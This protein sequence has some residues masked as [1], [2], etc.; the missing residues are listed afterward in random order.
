MSDPLGNGPRR[1]RVPP[2]RSRNRQPRAPGGP[3]RAQR[4]G[5]VAARG[6]SVT[7]G[8]QLTRVLV[9]VLSLAVLSRLLGPA[10]YGLVALALAVVAVGEVFREFGLSAAAVQ[11]KSLNPRQRDGLFWVNAYLGAT[12]TLTVA[13]G[14][15]V[16]ALA[17]SEPRLTPIARVL[18]LTFLLNG[19]AAQFRAGLQRQLRFS[20]LASV[21][22]V[23]QLLAALIGVVL[24]LRGAGYW[25]LVAQQVSQAAAALL[26]VVVLGGWLPRRPSRGE[27]LRPFLRYGWNYLG[28]QLI[29]YLGKNADSLVIGAHFGPV[30]LG[31]YN[32]AYQVLMGPLGQLRAPT[33]TVALPILSR[34][35]DDQRRYGEYV[36][37]GQVALGYTFLPAIAIAAGA[38]DPLV[39]VVLGDRWLPVVPIFAALACAAIFDTLPYVGYWVYLS[40]GL[41]PHLLRYTAAATA[42]RIACIAIGSTWGPVGV[43][44]GIAAAAGASWPLSL[45]RLSRLTPLPLAALVRGGLRILA[46]VGAAG[47]VSYGVSQ[48]L[49][50]WHPLPRL[51]AATAAALGVYALAGLALRSVRHDEGTILDILRRVL[52]AEGGVRGTG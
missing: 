38:A 45:W 11:A 15:P 14:A 6:A 37:R 50:G 51:A 1:I 17:F 7:V 28:G 52:R 5:T 43:A 39:R 20:A 3:A 12:L 49:G 4:L 36:V 48:A 33:T 26:L 24:A 34:L 2:S 35:Q 18:A 19:C 42:L 21:D 47:A 22:V 31:Y 8:G 27:G 40:R 25:A 13:V 46:M 10:D 32:R 41:T 9:Q 23:S 30:P 44:V 29:A 16:L